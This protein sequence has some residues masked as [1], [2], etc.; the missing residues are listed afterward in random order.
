[1]PMVLLTIY[2]PLR[3][4]GNQRRN[5]FLS[6]HPTKQASHSLSFVLPGSM[7]HCKPSLYSLCRV[8]LICLQSYLGTSSR[9]HN[10]Y[11]L[12]PFDLPLP[13]HVFRVPQYHSIDLRR[14]IRLWV[15]PLLQSSLGADSRHLPI[16]IDLL[17]PRSRCGH[18]VPGITI[19]LCFSGAYR[20]HNIYFS[21]ILQIVTCNVPA[22]HDLSETLSAVQISCRRSCNCGC[23]GLYII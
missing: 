18:L 4:L 15:P 9:A 5:F 13:L 6:C 2:D 7:H 12:R 14:N 22:S 20:L 23:C 11:S 8:L 16:S 19:R 21:Q 1:M 10:H 17:S 3:A